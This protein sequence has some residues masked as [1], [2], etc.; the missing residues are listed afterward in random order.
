[1]CAHPV[2][3]AQVSASA[4]FMHDVP[5]LTYP[6][7]CCEETIIPMHTALASISGIRCSGPGC[8]KVFHASWAQEPCFGSAFGR[9]TCCSEACET[10]AAEAAAEAAEV[11]A[12]EAE[13]HADA[14]AQAEAQTAA[15]QAAQ[16]AQ[17]GG[18]TTNA[19]T[20]EAAAEK[21]QA[22]VER[23]C[24]DFMTPKELDEV[25]ALKLSMM[26]E[27]VSPMA[28][29]RTR[30]EAASAAARIIMVREK[31]RG[32]LLGYANYY[33]NCLEDDR[34]VAYLYEV[35]L[36][37][38][39]QG[40]KPSLGKA[41]L[42]DFEE[43]ARQAGMAA[44]RLTVSA[45]NPKAISIYKHLGYGFVR[46]CTEHDT[47]T[48]ITYTSY[49]YEKA[50]GREAAAEVQQEEQ[51]VVPATAAESEEENTP[52]EDEA[53]T[54]E[55]P[56]PEEVDAAKRV[57]HVPVSDVVTWEQL[58]LLRRSALRTEGG[59]D[60]EEGDVGEDGDGDMSV[61]D[62]FRMLTRH[63]GLLAPTDVPADVQADL[64]TS[65]ALLEAVAPLVLQAE[66]QRARSADIR[67]QVD[68][69][70]G[71]LECVRLHG[72]ARD[73]ARLLGALE[74]AGVKL[75]EKMDV[76]VERT[77]RRVE[78]AQAEPSQGPSVP[79]LLVAAST[80]RR[81][82]TALGRGKSQVLKAANLIRRIVEGFDKELGSGDPTE[83]DEQ[84][85]RDCLDG[86]RGVDII[87]LTVQGLLGAAFGEEEAADKAATCTL[88]ASRLLIV[89]RDD[90]AGSDDDDDGG[91]GGGG[92]GVGAASASDDP[93][94][95]WAFL[96]RSSS[97]QL[98][99]DER[100][101]ALLARPARQ[102]EEAL[103]QAEGAP[104]PLHAKPKNMPGAVNKRIHKLGDA[105]GLSTG[106]NKTHR[107]FS[108]AALVVAAA[109]D[110]KALHADAIHHLMHDTCVRR[111]GAKANELCALCKVNSAMGGRFAKLATIDGGGGETLTEASLFALP[112]SRPAVLV[113]NEQGVDAM[114]S[115]A[116]RAIEQAAI[117]KH[118]LA[119][120]R[121]CNVL[122]KPPSEAE[123]AMAVFGLRAEAHQECPACKRPLPS[124]N[125]KEFAERVDACQPCSMRPY[126]SI[127]RR[128]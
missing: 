40:K 73:A 106:E 74:Q 101:C 113:A 92:S 79:P 87:V 75:M 42:A 78:E 121:Q 77:K 68:R 6:C 55:L 83:E 120:K 4:S 8:D 60:G 97:I 91:G 29:A 58:N 31:S 20:V 124:I 10:A 52:L 104:L 17:T 126:V 64:V 112:E 51:V 49:L 32:K 11:A 76:L 107:I 3:A 48:D 99:C 109:I 90:P 26:N 25:C 116:K 108:Q 45:L 30:N 12:A 53:V 46:E 38:E 61:D 89:A 98:W 18:S 41:L 111:A 16:A 67:L 19:V 125:C 5:T 127:G 23:R 44:M 27:L 66:A 96:L 21:L 122:P 22:K 7:D 80:M 71:N 119:R 94:V 82:R 115:G 34:R 47:G 65:K 50:C 70:V 114:V 63:L 62:A 110:N 9:G 84:A 69:R 54:P 72:E 56:S 28:M 36:A 15:A 105:T 128:T 95:K 102:L 2:A 59:G 117:G 33:L 86:M 35:Q 13:A 93:L 14:Q 39:A 123:V 81:Q 24:G 57:L 100:A 85:L 103:V 88:L 1:M 118:P 43:R 37:D